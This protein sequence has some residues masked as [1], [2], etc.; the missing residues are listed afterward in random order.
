MAK[1]SG[2]GKFR[3]FMVASVSSSPILSKT[4]FLDFRFNLH[5]RGSADSRSDSNIIV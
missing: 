4:D 1:F 3:N 5:N 2:V